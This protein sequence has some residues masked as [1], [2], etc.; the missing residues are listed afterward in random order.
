M[1][2]N[3]S[4]EEEEEDDDAGRPAGVYRRLIFLENEGVVQTEVS[5][6][7]CARL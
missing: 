6:K 1:S 4:Q 3:N 2:K 5:F 7:H